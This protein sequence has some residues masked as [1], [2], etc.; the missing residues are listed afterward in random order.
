L[1]HDI[2]KYEDSHE[3]PKIGYNILRDMSSG[4]LSFRTANLVRDHRLAQLYLDGELKKLKKVTNFVANPNFIDLMQLRRWDVMGRKKNVKPNW[5]HLKDKI[6]K[7][8]TGQS[9]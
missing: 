4:L 6:I 1:L 8:A 9:W 7:L 2:G 5:D 3:H